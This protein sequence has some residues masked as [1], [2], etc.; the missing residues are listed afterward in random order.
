MHCVK[1]LATYYSKNQSLP[2][3][4]T[5]C[6]LGYTDIKKWLQLKSK[7]VVSPILLNS[8]IDATTF[9]CIA[10]IECNIMHTWLYVTRETMLSKFCLH[11]QEKMAVW[12]S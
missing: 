1:L 7:I 12:L 10:L 5:Y 2:A 8:T 4:T 11:T 9:T 3:T 6:H